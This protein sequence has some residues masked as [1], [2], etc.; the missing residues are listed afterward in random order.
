M[1]SGILTGEGANMQYALLIY[2]ENSNREPTAAEGEAI[3]QEYNAF[4]QGLRD[5][6]AMVGGERLTDA[7][8]AT[9][10][11][12]RDGKKV[13]TDGPFAET[14]EY[15]GGFYIIEAPSLDGALEAAAMCPGAKYG[16][17]E[18]RPVYDMGG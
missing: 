14:K 1:R 9:T 16:S 4:G 13:V 3:M 15:L 17:V 6:N 18:V 12:I 5:R 7:S 10:V 8:S 2:Q 11:R